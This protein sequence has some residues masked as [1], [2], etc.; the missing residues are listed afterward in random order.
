MSEMSELEFRDDADWAATAWERKPPGYLGVR[1]VVLRTHKPPPRVVVD[2]L[3]PS[4]TL[5][6]LLGAFFAPALWR[7]SHRLLSPRVTK[8]PRTSKVRYSPIK[9][10]EEKVGQR[11]RGTNLAVPAGCRTRTARRDARFA[12]SGKGGGARVYQK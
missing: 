7:V 5:F 11:A 2:F 4:M 9:E 1:A 3:R 6:S 12:L 10:K 8:I